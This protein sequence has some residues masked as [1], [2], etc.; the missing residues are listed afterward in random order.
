MAHDITSS[1]KWGLTVSIQKT[2]GMA[3]SGGGGESIDLDDGGHIE[4]VSDF[5]YL[6]SNISAGGSVSAEVS[7]RLAKASRA[8]GCLL[9]PIFQCL[10]LSISAYGV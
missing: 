4:M 1:S 10:A 6:G 9:K 7:R 2:K 5:T 8:F 3:T